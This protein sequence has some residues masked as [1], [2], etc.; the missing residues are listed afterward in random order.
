MDNEP[1]VS[2][3]VADRPLTCSSCGRGIAVGD[4]VL[5]I[6]HRSIVETTHVVCPLADGSAP[7]RA[8]M[9]DLLK[10]LR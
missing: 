4:R 8:L 9:R 6:T 2:E 10:E 7:A 3:Y 1:R 5:T